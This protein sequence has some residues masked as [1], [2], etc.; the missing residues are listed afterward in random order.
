M[1]VI[2]LGATMVL[3]PAFQKSDPIAFAEVYGLVEPGDLEVRCSALNVEHRNPLRK[4]H[5]EEANRA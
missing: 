5:D 4:L 3:P 2:L 1:G